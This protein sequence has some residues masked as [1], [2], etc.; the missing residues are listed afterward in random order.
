MKPHLLHEIVTSIR[1]VKIAIIG[2]FCLDAYWFVDES[3][4]EISIETGQPTRPV[5]Q[6]KYSLGGA[7]NVANN[8]A[9]MEV[10]DIRAFGVIGSDPF[11]TEMVSIMNKTGID[12]RNL[13]TQG[14]EWAT[15]VYIKPYLND[16][17]QSRIDF[18]NYNRLSD[19]TANLLIE[20]IN[21][22]I[23][24]VDLVIINQQVLSG[25]HTEYFR[26][27]LVEVISFFPEKIFIAD[28][29]NYTGIYKGAYRKMNDNEA[30]RL[31][32]IVIEPDETV[33]YPEVLKAA[34]SLYE[35][36]RKPLLITR[37][38]RGSIITDDKG[39]SEIAGLMI[40]SKVDTVGAGDSYLPVLQRPGCRIFT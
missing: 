2:D 18:G 4:S 14:K 38:S 9:A 26:Q 25:I 7:G 10:K 13:L 37:G 29:R 32:G 40:I 23:N 34:E 21:A 8:L 3:T 39:I 33:P 24:E 31:C 17:E 28:S 19:E 20:R 22:E 15:H 36:Y 12:T 35:S 27:K 1:S 6:Q 16:A 11:G 5:R 30:V